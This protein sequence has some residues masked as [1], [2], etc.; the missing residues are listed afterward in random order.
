MEDGKHR[1]AEPM[2]SKPKQLKPIKVFLHP[3]LTASHRQAPIVSQL[4]YCN[5]RMKSK[6]LKKT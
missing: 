4:H 6:L 5:G 3:I 1:L 2:F